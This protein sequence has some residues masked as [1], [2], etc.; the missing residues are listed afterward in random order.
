LRFTGD[1]T[2]LAAA[3]SVEQEGLTP[4]DAL[5]STKRATHRLQRRLTERIRL[6]ERATADGEEAHLRLPPHGLRS[7]SERRT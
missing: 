5:H 7:P 6:E 3:S 1:V 2:V 4:F